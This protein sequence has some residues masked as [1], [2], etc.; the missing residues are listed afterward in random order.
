MT[1]RGD[2]A[3]GQRCQVNHR[4]RAKAPRG[5]G[6]SISQ[7]QPAFRI[8]I[9]YLN[10]LAAVTPQDISRAIG[11][12]AN[13]IFSERQHRHCWCGGLPQRQRQHRTCRRR[14]ARH[15]A[16]HFFHAG[17]GLD[18]NAARVKANPLADKGNRCGLQLARPTQHDKPGAMFCPAPHCAK[19]AHAKRG[20]ALA[21]Q[22]FNLQ[23]KLS[24]CAQPFGEACGV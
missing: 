11:S 18:G 23:A 6:Q 21:F 24:Q 4:T 1:K 13:G 2:D 16:A 3:A 20:Q 12:G 8:R 14:S 15:I 17:G 7:D 22:H 9:Q 5:I 19:R 10:R